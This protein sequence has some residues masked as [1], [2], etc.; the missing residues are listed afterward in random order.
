[1][2]NKLKAL[3]GMAMHRDAFSKLSQ[4]AQVDALPAGGDE[5]L[6]AMRCA[7]AIIAYT[8]PF[9]PE[10]LRE[11][12]NLKVIS[13]HACPQPLLTEAAHRGIAVT[14]VPTLWDTVADMTLGL[15]FAAARNIPQAHEAICNG[16]WQ[17][18]TALK[19]KY[20]GLDVFGKTLGILGLGQIGSILAKRVKGF[21]MAVLYYDSVRRPA[22]EEKLGVRYK[23]FHEVIS[24]SDFLAVLVPLTD[25]TR[26]MLG[27]PE[28]RMMKKDMVILNTARGAILDENALYRA[29]A[30][31][32]I[33]AAGLDVFVDEPIRPD[34]PLLT[35]DNVVFTPHLGGSTK[36]CDMTLVDDA[37]R[38]LNGEKPVY[39]ASV[40]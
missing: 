17:D 24:E 39:G 26:G 23:P 15:M 34:N 22:L 30:E 6:E 35:L 1:M 37:I 8:P 13:C 12:R 31:G 33:A 32:R 11:A 9:G 19:V 5:L 16:L 3:C 27:E 38:V 29:L 40:F 7:A 21:D 36:Q 10:A 18:G 20:S 4:V 2:E 28:F 14:L 25:D